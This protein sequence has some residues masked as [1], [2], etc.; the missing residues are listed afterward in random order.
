MSKKSKTIFGIFTES[1]GLY[2]SNFNKFV[3]YMSFPVLGQIAGL[4]LIFGITYL[5]TQ[6][7]PKLLEKYPNLD[8]LNTLIILSIIITLPGLAIFTKAFWE[9]LIAYGAINSMYE[10]LHKSGRVYDFKAHTE[11]ITRRASAFIGLWCLFGIFS[12]LASFPLLWVIGGILAVYFV[13]IFQAFT[14]ESESSPFSCF[15]KS[16]SLIKGNFGK[17]FVLLILIGTLTYLIIPQLTC[18]LMQISRITNFFTGALLPIANMIPDLHL[19]QYGLKPITSYDYSLMIFEGLVAQ[20]LIQYTL[21]MR[22]I[23]WAMWY[24]ALD[25]TPSVQ[26][27]KSSKKRPSEKLME[28]SHKKLTKK[29]IDKN[30]LKR[31]M[32][33]DDEE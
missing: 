2:F 25:K 22:S 30:L 29:K 12:L 4:A 18:K 11:V 1:V 23:L 33:K 32:E 24:K 7:L 14:Y 26:T 13:L 9:Y 27:K 5:Y 20:I 17:T 6:N 21:P 8:N 16:F 10:N 19:E 28:E 3:K 15:K 31:A